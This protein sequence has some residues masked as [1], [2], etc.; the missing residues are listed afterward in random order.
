M[1]QVLLGSIITVVVLV[2]GYL[3]VKHVRRIAL[4]TTFVAV[5]GLAWFLLDKNTGLSHIWCGVI[6][7]IIGGAILLLLSKVIS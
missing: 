1:N 7:L 4:I 2:G 6:G 5:A 3:A